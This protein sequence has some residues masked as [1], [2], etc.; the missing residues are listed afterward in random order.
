MCESRSEE[1]TKQSSEVEGGRKLG[2]RG[3][4][5]GNGDQVWGEGVWGR[6]QQLTG[7]LWK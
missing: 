5:E 6:G 1:E 3:G 4:E 2:R 7:H